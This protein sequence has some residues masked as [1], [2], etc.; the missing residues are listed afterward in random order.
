MDDA[1]ATGADTI[2]VACPT[3]CQMLEGVIGPRPEVKD[4]AEL[5]LA[6]LEG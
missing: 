3:C 1:R 5:L 4:V 2:A 6:A